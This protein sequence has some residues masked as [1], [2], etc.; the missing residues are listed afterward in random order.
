MSRTPASL[1]I[2]IVLLLTAAS[3]PAIAQNTPAYPTKY[4]TAS[5][6]SDHFINDSVD[7]EYKLHY[8]ASAQDANEILTSVRNMVDP[9]TKVFLVPSTA[10]IA[11]HAP[12]EVQAQIARLLAALDQPHARYRLTYTMTEM[13]GTRKIGVQRFSMVVLS[14]H[15]SQMKQGS[16]LPI[17]TGGISTQFTYIDVG[18]NF[19]ATLV[20]IQGGG[21]LKSKVEQT[22]IAPDSITPSNPNPVLR[23]TRLEGTTSLTLNKPQ[24]LGALDVPSSTHHFDVEVVMEPVN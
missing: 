8:A 24:L 20:E 7:R 23:D 1:A 16:R 21:V 11:V 10:I 3:V 13:D 19:D 14:G 17:S 22:S 5:E 2:S 4:P 12:D 15:G 9:Q 18:M 6:R